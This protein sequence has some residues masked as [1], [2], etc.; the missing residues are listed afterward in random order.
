MSGVNTKSLSTERPQS[1]CS[2]K[3]PDMSQV[4]KNKENTELLTDTEICA[5]M[6]KKN[7]QQ[8][9]NHFTPLIWAVL[10]NIDMCQDWDTNS[11][12]DTLEISKQDMKDILEGK[13]TQNV[14][15][16]FLKILASLN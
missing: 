7:I 14:M 11:L 8:V 13:H 1:S 10:Q 9:I 12:A 5:L 4:N 3:I 16:C 6:D 15:P 2:D